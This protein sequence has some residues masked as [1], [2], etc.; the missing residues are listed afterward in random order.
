MASF[1]DEIGT[2]IN[3]YMDGLGAEIASRFSLDVREVNKVVTRFRSFPRAF[4]HRS[5]ADSS[6]EWRSGRSP[7]AASGATSPP[8]ATPPLLRPSSMTMSKSSE[9]PS[10]RAILFTRYSR[11][12]S[13]GSTP[14]GAAFLTTGETPVLTPLLKDCGC[15]FIPDIAEAGKTGGWVFPIEHFDRIRELLLSRGFV[16]TVDPVAALPVIETAPTRARASEL[17]AKFRSPPTESE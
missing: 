2:M 4:H 13:P 17:V 8:T 11:G 5:R 15:R 1:T 3:A 10:I 6:S 9:F 7:E 12:G 14:C 16:L